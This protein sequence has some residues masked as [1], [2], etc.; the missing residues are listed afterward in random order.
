MCVTPVHRSLVKMAMHRGH[1]LSGL[2][3][4]EFLHKDACVSC[5]QCKGTSSSQYHPS[6]QVAKGLPTVVTIASKD[7]DVARR[8]QVLLSNSRFRCYTTDDIEGVLSFKLQSTFPILRRMTG[9]IGNA[10]LAMSGGGVGGVDCLKAPK[11]HIRCARL[12]VPGC[13]NCPHRIG[14][15]LEQCS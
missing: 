15:L 9:R 4:P 7:Q 8:A 10:R 2:S 6:M 5:C 1:V 12:A 13:K 14:V 11:T 3:R